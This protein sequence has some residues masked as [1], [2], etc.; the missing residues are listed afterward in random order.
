M[1]DS[2]WRG[3]TE[4]QQGLQPVAGGLPIGVIIIRCGSALHTSQHN[5]KLGFGYDSRRLCASAASWCVTAQ[6]RDP[7]RLTECLPAT[8]RLVSRHLVVNTL[9]APPKKYCT[10]LQP[11]YVA[12]CGATLSGKPCGSR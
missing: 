7:M 6:Q 1:H 2:C 9:M 12:Y 4:D 8:P 3:C 11:M 10:P 5:Y